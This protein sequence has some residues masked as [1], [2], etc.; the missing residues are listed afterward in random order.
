MKNL[1]LVLVLLV[2]AFL[3]VQQKTTVLDPYV[4]E[5]APALSSLKKKPAEEAVEPS[6]GSPP[7]KP[8]S[9][10]P[11]QLLELKNKEGR[12]VQARILGLNSATVTIQTSDGKVYDYPL[13]NLDAGTIATLQ[14]ISSF[15]YP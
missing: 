3:V 14:A 2:A 5:Y 4:E 10:T 8:S 1:V 7:F 13:N 11:S 9:Q 12:T 15:P 6:L